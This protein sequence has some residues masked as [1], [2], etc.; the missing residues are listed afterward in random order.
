MLITTD[1]LTI[2]LYISTVCSVLLILKTVFQFFKWLL[3]I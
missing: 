1:F 2:F 3:G